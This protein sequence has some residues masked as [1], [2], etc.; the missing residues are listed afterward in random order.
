MDGIRVKTSKNELEKLYIEKKMSCKS[1][2]SMLRC[3]GTQ[4]RDRLIEYDISIRKNVKIEIPE[5]ELRELYLKKMMS[6]DEIAKRFGYSQSVI[7]SRLAMYSIP[8]RISIGGRPGK[9]QIYKKQCQYHNCPN[10]PFTTL[11]EKQQFCSHRCYNASTRTLKGTQRECAN[12]NCRKQFEPTQSK[13]QCCGP[14]CASKKS[15]ISHMKHEYNI[16]DG[17]T[18]RERRNFIQNKKRNE[19][20]KTDPGFRLN[21]RMRKAIY[22]SILG[23]KNGRH[24]EHLVGWTLKQ[25]KT[26]LQKL[27]QSGMTWDN[28]GKWHVDHIV[29]I[30]VHNFSKPE[31][32]DFKRCW[33]LSNLQPMWGPEN[34]S[35]GARIEKHFQPKLQ[36][37]IKEAG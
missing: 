22:F 25:L 9:R 2:G 13:Q 15:G 4:V 35:K 32:P 29:P 23:R 28:Y 3:S 1:I 7:S 26:H 21:E 18:K 24:W 6:T 20:A 16:P 34:Q 19:R 17:L 8:A 33:A 12:S 31:H 11:R 5:S 10:P 27:F 30:S 37:E 36:L 14:E